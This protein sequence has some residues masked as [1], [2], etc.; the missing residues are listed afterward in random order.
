METYYLTCT[1]YNSV[2]EIG[3]DKKD[4]QL[5]L[6]TSNDLIHWTRRGV[7]L[8]AYQGKWNHGWT[9]SGAIVPIKIDG[10]YWMYYL[11]EGPHSA[12]DMGVA[13][14]DDLLQWT[15]ASDQPVAPVRAG[16]FDSKVAEPGPSPVL[17]SDRILLI[18]NGADDH[19]VYSTSW[20]LFDAKD[21]A[22]VLE[23]AE[24]PLFH[25]I[26][27][28]EKVGQVPNVV[29]V[30]GSIRRGQQRLFYYGGADQYIGVAAARSR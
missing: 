12:G 7:I 20:I 2:D 26:E 9:K 18:H 28:W 8:P 14:S 6:A 24:K 21:P 3:K 1:G 11:G 25:P 4:A 15:D 17:T 29:F 19:L 27:S 22:K 5:C 30:E 23:R 13:T 16:Y 10:K